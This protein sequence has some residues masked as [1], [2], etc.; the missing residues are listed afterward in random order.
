MLPFPRYCFGVIICLL[1]FIFVTF[2]IVFL[3]F[4]GEATERTRIWIKGT[5]DPSTTSDSPTTPGTSAEM[6]TTQIAPPNASNEE[7]PEN[8]DSASHPAGEGA[9]ALAARVKRELVQRLDGASLKERYPD[10]ST[11]DR[12]EMFN[13]P[14]SP[15]E[16]FLH[17]SEHRD[18]WDCINDYEAELKH[19]LTILGWLFLSLSL[20]TQC[21]ACIHGMII[22]LSQQPKKRPAIVMHQSVSHRSGIPPA[23]DEE[24]RQMLSQARSPSSARLSSSSQRI[25][26]ADYYDNADL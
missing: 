23:L 17:F 13:W 22:R 8:A 7:D 5:P 1:S 25:S 24:D 6:S 10:L 3:A 9:R 21:A 12:C 2:A 18:E 14:Q 15:P 26:S 16:D 20:V 19:G 4:A 11:T